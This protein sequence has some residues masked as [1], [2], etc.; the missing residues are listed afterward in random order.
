MNLT[1][2][3]A[4]LACTLCM[5]LSTAAMALTLDDIKQMAAVGVPD[6]IIISTIEG[7]EETFNLNAQDIIDLK[8]AGISDAVIEALQGT[9]GTTT[10]SKPAL[11]DEDD[12]QRSRADSADREEAPR[13]RSSRRRSFSDDSEDSDD[14][15]IRRRRR[16][17]TTE[18]N[19]D[20]DQ[21]DSLI[22]RRRGSRDD[23]RE[24]GSERT[25]S[26]VKRTPKKIKAAIANYKEKKFLTA[27]LKLYRLAESGK[28][29]EFEAK[30]NYY[31]GGSLEKLGLLHSAQV[32]FQK[33]VKE[34][35]SSGALFANSLAKMVSISDK[36]NDPIYL[37]R[38]IDKISPDDYP[39]KV[40]DDLYYYQG[41][42][43]F[44]KGDYKQAE[45]NFSKLGRSNRHFVQA[46]Y[47]LGVIYNQQ[48]RRKRA[49]KVFADIINR[50]FR[51]DPQTIASIKQLSFINMARIR[52]SVQQYSKAAELYERLPRLATHWSTSLYEA[53]W[54]HFMSENKE[55]KALGHLLTIHSPFF[56]KVWV[57]EARILEALTYY[58][59]CEYGYVEDILDDFKANYGPVQATIDRVLEPYTAG[60][61]P[62][63]ELY[64]SLYSSTSREYRDLPQAVF[65]RVESNR[66]FAGPHNRVLQIEKELRRIR[67]LKPQWRD[68]EVGKALVPMLRKQRGIYMKIAGIALANELDRVRLGL[69]DLMGQEALIRFEVVSGEYRKYQTRFRNPEA[70]DVQEGIEFDFA[71][72]PDLIYWPFNDE[73]W[74]D[75]LGYYERVEPGDCKE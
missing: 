27:S 31:L 9:A 68:S 46:R 43:N 4:S 49:F 74:E 22:R 7:A 63:K 16:G 23:N 35:P 57:P 70:A 38:S 41:I 72:N 33:V 45:R 51:G 56:R 47:Y 34:G 30:I 50:D 28:F 59:I 10:R 53:A 65:A 19:T 73:Y 39:G 42:R 66:R 37:I 20:S 48:N 60:E 25:D 64:R 26:R 58:R 17:A 5:L 32:Y 21:E 15:M 67:Q 2:L 8:G 71:T 62:L 24:R 12:S 69:G 40:K 36:T 44:E 29:P 3:V 18:S 6:N 61:K 54:A 11:R 52:Y 1:K 14:S 55:Y 13:S 75:E